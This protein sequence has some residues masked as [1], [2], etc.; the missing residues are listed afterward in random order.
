MKYYKNLDTDEIITIDDIKRI[1]EEDKEEQAR[2]NDIHSFEEYLDTF[3]GLGGPY[4]YIGDDLTKEE[5]K[6]YEGRET[7][8]ED[9]DLVTFCYIKEI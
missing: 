5:I 9:D 4:F 6:K 8:Q 2:M 7:D 1:Y 3:S